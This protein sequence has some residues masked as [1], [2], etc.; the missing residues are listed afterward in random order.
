MAIINCLKAGQCPWVLLAIVAVFSST[1]VAQNSEQGQ[2]PKPAINDEA[3]SK[4]QVGS[5]SDAQ[6]KDLLG[7]PWRI[8]NYGETYCGCR[9]AEPQEVWEYRGADASGSYKFHLEFD[10]D[11][12]VRVAAKIPDDAKEA[13]QAS[14]G[15]HP[16]RAKR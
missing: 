1:T 9:H 11:G 2:A 16:W 3:F 14:S 4:I 10:D 13:S 7:T 5:S 8:T 6:V 15:K 12:I